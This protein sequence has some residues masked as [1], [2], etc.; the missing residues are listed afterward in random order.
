MKVKSARKFGA[1]DQ[2]K[3]SSVSFCII[4]VVNDQYV[5]RKIR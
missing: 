3:S 2:Q 5:N 1:L 4:A